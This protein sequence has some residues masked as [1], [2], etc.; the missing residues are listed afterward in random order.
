MLKAEKSFPPVSRKDE[1]STL[2]SVRHQLLKR[3]IEIPERLLEKKDV[4]K[5]LKGR[6]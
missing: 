4:S 5:C 3:I 1:F 2:S 6:R